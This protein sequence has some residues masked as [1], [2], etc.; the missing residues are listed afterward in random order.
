VSVRLSAFV[1]LEAYLANLVKDP[2]IQPPNRSQSTLWQDWIFFEQGSATPCHGRP[3][4]TGEIKM[5]D[6]SETAH[7]D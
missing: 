5:D 3:T 4:D 6:G 2:A 7:N 1:Q